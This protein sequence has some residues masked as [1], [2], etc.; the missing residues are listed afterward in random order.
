MNSTMAAECLPDGLIVVNLSIL[1]R[2]TLAF[3]IFSATAFGEGQFKYRVASTPN[4]LII[5]CWR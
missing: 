1:L 4:G 2:T 3:L 5:V